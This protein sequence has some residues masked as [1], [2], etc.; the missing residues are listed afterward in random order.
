MWHLGRKLNRWLDQAL[1]DK[2]AGLPS[3]MERVES[4]ETKLADHLQWHADP[5]GRPAKPAPVRP[6]GPQPRH[7]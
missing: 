7:R 6:N 3:L 4:I 1:G 5:G 2:Q